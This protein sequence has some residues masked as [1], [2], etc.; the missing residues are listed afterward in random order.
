M[1]RALYT[2]STGMG[3]QQLNM[4]TLAHNMSNVNT[5]GFKKQRVEFQDL[6]Y[7]T[8]RRPAADEDRNEPVG[9]AVGLGVRP[10]AINTLFAQGNLQSTQNP[11]DVAISGPGFFA[12]QVPGYEEP[13]YTRD[14]AIKV[15]AEG[16][17]VTA[18]GYL[19]LG[20][21]ALE[22]NYTDVRIGADGKVTYMLPND[23][24][25][26]DKGE[27]LQIFKFSNPAGLQKIG[28]NLYQATPNSGEAVQWE[29]DSDNSI[30]L[31]SEYL[32]MSNVQVVE[33]M[34]NLITAQRA[35]EFNSKVIQSSD[36]MLQTAANL[37]R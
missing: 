35:Y 5:I 22:E 15:D 8:I 13:L 31:H 6:L 34:V 1:M 27:P 2:A 10:A 28:K 17:L 36:E 9:L 12:V 33:E 4:D 3:A 23:P 19:Y 32:E 24:D 26:Q 30:A 18:D 16:Q 29:P 37:R 11:L 21:E 25:P 14:G 7:Q 20:P